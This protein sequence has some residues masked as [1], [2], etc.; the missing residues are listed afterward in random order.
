MSSTTTN[1]TSTKTSASVDLIH[2]FI[3]GVIRSFYNEID[4]NNKKAAD[5]MQS[6]GSDAAA[7]FM[8]KSAGMDY[9]KM[10]SLYG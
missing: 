5:V 10:R 2:P 9:A 1:T 7:D 3:S 8:L 4:S 6:K